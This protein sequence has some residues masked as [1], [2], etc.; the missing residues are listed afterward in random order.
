MPP[1]RQKK[2]ATVITND[3]TIHQ[4]GSNSLNKNRQQ[5]NHTPLRLCKMMEHSREIHLQHKCCFDLTIFAHKAGGGLYWIRPNSTTL[6]KKMMMAVWS[7][8]FFKITRSFARGCSSGYWRGDFFL[9]L[10]LLLLLLL[11]VRKRGRHVPFLSWSVF[12][13][14]DASL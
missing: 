1:R 8:F 4:K 7:S 3:G 11:L 14:P 10:V 6:P 9:R 5:D 13:I 2:A 12:H